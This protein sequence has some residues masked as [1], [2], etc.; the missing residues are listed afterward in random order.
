ST[1]HHHFRQ[2]HHPPPTT[3]PR[4]HHMSFQER[5]TI[6]F[7]IVAVVGY[8]VYLVLV[9]PSLGTTPVPEIQYWIPMLATIGGAV[10]AG[11]IG[12]IV[13]GITAGAATRGR[14]PVED[15]RDRQIDHL[16]E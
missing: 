15:E 16:G 4:S 14:A 10:V 12:G 13:L 6:A 2:N 5:N 7:G 8:V 3:R 11:I 9:V 1:T